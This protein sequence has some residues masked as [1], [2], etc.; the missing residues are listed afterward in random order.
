VCAGWKAV[1]DAL[2]MRLVPRWQTTDEAMGMLVRRFP[3]VASLEYKGNEWR[4]LTDEV[5]RALSSLAALSTIHLF[6][7]PS[8]GRGEAGAAHRH[9]PPALPPPYSCCRAAPQRTPRSATVYSASRGGPPSLAVQP[10]LQY[11]SAV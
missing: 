3:A 8:D 2:V 7:C 6:N 9:P 4:V 11:H 5:L 1:Y 10:Q